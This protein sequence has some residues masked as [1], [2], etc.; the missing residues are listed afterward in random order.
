MSIS[1]R[2][3]LRQRASMTSLVIPERMSFIEYI[4]NNVS[5]SKLQDLI[6]VCL[7]KKNKSQQ[8]HIN[9]LPEEDSFYFRGNITYFDNYLKGTN[10]FFNFSHIG[11]LEEILEELIKQILFKQV[12]LKSKKKFSISIFTKNNNYNS[13]VNNN[14]IYEVDKTENGSEDN[15]TCP[16]CVSDYDRKEK[17]TLKCGHTM[18]SSCFWSS[19]DNNILTCPLCRESFFSRN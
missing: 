6:I 16:I 12:A 17:L 4:K 7:S 1:R 11:R 10:E 3:I 8:V 9:F 18:C 5:E 13:D 2:N 19:I 14:Y 15:N